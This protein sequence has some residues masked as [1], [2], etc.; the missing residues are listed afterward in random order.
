MILFVMQW[1][2]I[3]MGHCKYFAIVCAVCYY[4]MCGKL[5]QPKIKIYKIDKLYA[6]ADY[7]VNK[8]YGIFTAVK[9]YC[10][11]CSNLL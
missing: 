5:M 9:C 3:P 6:T 8:G 11:L 1:N 7:A 2:P 4:N 10:C